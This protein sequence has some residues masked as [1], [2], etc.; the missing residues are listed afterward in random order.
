MAKS[1]A[2]KDGDWKEHK[3]WH[4][5]KMLIAGLIIL[6][7]VYWP[8]MDSW[9]LIGALLAIAGILKLIWAYK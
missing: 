2:M 5:W 6:I 9:A 7:N 4:G 8:F 3:K 1:M